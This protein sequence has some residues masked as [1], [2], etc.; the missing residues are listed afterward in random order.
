MHMALKQRLFLP[1]VFCMYGAAL[2]NVLD[3]LGDLYE[4]T[5]LGTLGNVECHPE[6]F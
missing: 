6:H 2:S 5:L 1:A 3:D 4:L